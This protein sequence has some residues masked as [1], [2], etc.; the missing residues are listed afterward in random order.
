MHAGMKKAA[1]QSCLPTNEEDDEKSVSMCDGV[2]SM[3]LQ[4]K[5]EIPEPIARGIS[6]GQYTDSKRGTR[7]R[8]K[9]GG[10]SG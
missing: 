7:W 4:R 10:K 3:I 9:S 8:C 5:V 1:P 2:G 6:P